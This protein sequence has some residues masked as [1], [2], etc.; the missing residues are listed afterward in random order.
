[1]N[2]SIIRMSAVVMLGVSV[3]VGFLLK[4]QVENDTGPVAQIPVTVSTLRITQVE[5]TTAMPF[6]YGISLPSA[7]IEAQDRA[8]L[9]APIHFGP[10][11]AWQGSVKTPRRPPH[12]SASFLRPFVQLSHSSALDGITNIQFTAGETAEDET[13][14]AQDVACEPLMRVDLQ[15]GA[16]LRVLFSAPCNKG[17]RVE[18]AHGELYFTEVVDEDG[19]ILAF[20]PAM[21]SPAQIVLRMEQGDDLS[22]SIDVPELGDHFRVGLITQAMMD[23]ELHALT[24]GASYGEA[25]HIY[26]GNPGLDPAAGR[27]FVLGT[28]D[29]AFP[30]QAQIYTAPIEAIATDGAPEIVVELQVNDANCGLDRIA[31]TLKS[32]ENQMLNDL[33]EV[34]LPECDAVGD[35]LMLS[36]MF[37]PMQLADASQ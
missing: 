1:M 16:I 13:A 2:E 30:V 20:L 12:S 28:S 5:D 15:D 26:A 33:I 21:A 18:I 17:E 34:A 19:G 24:P 22:E 3:S 23:F 4:T 31:M 6:D 8:V 9:V 7:P 14:A 32:R 25:G 37:S 35:M 10:A 36:G 29:V 27:M 11:T